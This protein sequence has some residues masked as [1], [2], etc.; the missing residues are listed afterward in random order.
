MNNPNLSIVIP[1]YNAAKYINECV[2]SVINQ[3]YKN[4]EIILVNDG[5]TDNSLNILRALEK[6]DKRIR[7]FDLE[8][9]GVSNARNFGMKKAKGNYIGFVD[10][11][12]LIDQRMYSTLIENMESE[13]LDVIMCARENF[14]SHTS[15]TNK[16]FLELKPYVKLKKE[17]YEKQLLPLIVKLDDSLSSVWSKVYRKSIIIQN[18]IIF[19]VDLN[20]NED[21]NFNMDFLYSSNSFM[22]VNEP[23]Y[24]YRV[25]ND[26]SLSRKFRNDYLEIYKNK[27]LNV[28][29]KFNLN[30][31]ENKKL[32][33][34]ANEN[35]CY[36]A[37]FSI[38]NE[39][40]KRNN[41]GF[42]EKIKNAK[43][44]M[45][46]QLLRD[47][48]KDIKLKDKKLSKKI[49]LYSIEKNN[50]LLLF[51]FSLVFNSFKK[52]YE[53]LVIIK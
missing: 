43:N 29:N 42:L 17:S 7:I 51:M 16:I 41:L 50:L 18:N 10:S 23:F 14:Y 27:Y 31:K 28:H 24:K 1:V 3:D 52:T 25:E 13:N 44:M 38:V 45:D 21:W 8:N 39:F 26:Q 20:I 15:K 22:Y 4:L 49:R 12:D 11:D 5:S 33:D 37:S 32:L 40:D 9:Q 34:V 53:K 48:S 47:L 35:F 2:K 30:K 36:Y 46:D 19:D 6:E